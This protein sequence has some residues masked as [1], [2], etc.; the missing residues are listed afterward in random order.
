MVLNGANL[1]DSLHTNYNFK[2]ALNNS[3]LYL[4]NYTLGIM[5]KIILMFGSILI[6]SMIIVSLSF[7]EVAKSVKEEKKEIIG[8]WRQIEG[9]A[10]L[11]FKKDMKLYW[12]TNKVSP[13]MVFLYKISNAPIQCGQ[14]VEISN[15]YN[16]SFLE[17]IELNDHS[18][19]CYEING[20]GEK[21]MSL[22]GLGM[23]TPNLFERVTDKKK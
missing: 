22:T 3:R 21:N 14:K 7:Q 17:L 12:Y 1:Q 6:I 13:I 4:L 19:F 18:K 11:V 5:K 15:N 2:Q 16:T 8:T 10:T 23:A 9:E 20:I